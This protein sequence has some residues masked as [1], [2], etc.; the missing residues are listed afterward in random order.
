MNNIYD[1]LDNLNITYDEYKHEAVFT[2]AET[3]DIP[4]KIPGQH[5]KNLFLKNRKG[6]QYYLLIADD[7]KR[8]DIKHITKEINEKSLSF[9]SEEKLKS[10]LRLT[11]GSVTPFGLINDIDKHVKVLLDKDLGLC[12]YITFHPNVNTST[13]LLSY[14]DFIKFLEY[15][16]NEFTYVNIT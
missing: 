10:I 14:N 4:M 5:C 7:S 15:C 16:G 12:N 2:V 9:A 13:L 11:P 6:D 1:I 8:V 3:K